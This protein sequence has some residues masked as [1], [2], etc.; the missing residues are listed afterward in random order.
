ML[1]GG[2]L[3]T[4][5]K[6]YAYA[7]ARL[8]QVAM[9]Q[10]PHRAELRIFVSQKRPERVHKPKSSGPPQCLAQFPQDRLRSFHCSRSRGVQAQAGLL[11]GE[12]WSGGK[13]VKRSS[14]TPWLL[15]MATRH[16]GPPTVCCVPITR[17]CCT[18]LLGC[19]MIL[20]ARPLLRA[21]P[22][23][24]LPALTAGS[25]AVT[26]MSKEGSYTYK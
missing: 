20:A 15:L 5:L 16:R 19:C 14:S 3:P 1:G 26:S 9:Y 13:P 12:P 21:V 23:P 2:S 8:T 17:R 24:H 7:P 22:R 6:A 18:A 25:R 11:L 10:N 4:A